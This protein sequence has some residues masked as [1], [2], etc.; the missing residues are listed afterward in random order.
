MTQI[1]P[2][3]KRWGIVVGVD[4]YINAC[5]YLRNLQGCVTDANRMYQTM[6]DKDCCGFDE[7]HVRLL[8][9]PTYSQIE[10]AFKDLGGRMKK[11]DELWFYFAGH[12]YSE[13]RRNK[14][15][16]GYLLPS[17][18][19]FNE[20]GTL[21]TQSCISH[22]Q[23][24]DSFIDR[25]MG[26]GNITVVLFFDCCCAASVGLCD[27]SRAVAGTNDKE[28]ADG[29]KT[30]FRDLETIGA[31]EEGGDW[32]YQYLSF[33]ATDKTGKAKEDASGGVFT[34]YLIEGLRGGTQDCP[35]VG[36]NIADFYIRA[37]KLGV[38]LG[39]HVP[40][41]PPL[42]D[43]IDMTYPLSVSK[44]RKK[45]QEKIQQMDK[46]VIAWL[47]KMKEKRLLEKDARQFAEDIIFESESKEFRYAGMLRNLM[48]LFSANPELA[49]QLD[50]GARLINAFC[51]L[52]NLLEKNFEG[53]SPVV[54][55]M[56]VPPNSP[57]MTPHDKKL[58]ADVENRLR[59][60]DGEP[61][62]DLSDVGR[63]TQAEAAAKLDVVARKWMRKMCASDFYTPLYVKNERAE[64]KNKA[65][66]GFT[67]VFEAA[68]FELVKDD[69]K[70]ASRKR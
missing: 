19:G 49:Q 26:Y 59:A 55:P 3:S 29:F 17:D 45:S 41:Q 42:Q 58:L 70:L 64:W 62:D 68:V 20:D 1:R 35:T 48:R 14:R 5:Q 11:G 15:V 32:D 57:P 40:N 22:D 51:E 9:N 33:M 18:I 8:E 23:L 60:A 47:S 43:F 39:D 44:A 67:S 61:S 69:E 52:K 12:G 50:E 2:A 66:K 46:L 10:N 7:S 30:S 31:A 6:V 24:R 28:V 21:S 25:H 27:G 34:K 63:K 13:R 56:P 65:Q 38:F 36:S 53:M 54:G 37:G 4:E 16:S